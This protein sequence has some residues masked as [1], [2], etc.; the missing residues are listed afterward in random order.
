[1]Q[2]MISIIINFPTNLGDTIIS[3][4]IL[5]RLK[6]NF[7]ESKIT[8]IVSPQT[9]EFLLRNTFID[10]VVVFDKAWKLRQKMRFSFSLRGKYDLIVDLK[11]SLLPVI[12]GVKKRTP[13][14]RNYPKDIH[15]KD[16]YLKLVQK[17]A[18]IFQNTKSTFLLEKK[19]KEKWSNLNLT[20]AIFVACSARSSIK[21]YSY[22]HL[23]E[24][25]N[26]LLKKGYSIVVLGTK[27]EVHFYK[28]ILSLKGV[29]D[30][31]G[32]TKMSDCFYL[33]EKYASLVLCVDS[34]LMHLASYLNLPIVAL[35]GPTNIKR[36]SPW[37]ANYVVLYRKDL[38]CVFCEKS[39]CENPRCMEILPQKVIEA[40]EEMIARYVL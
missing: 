9:K 2:R 32:E 28:D 17:I 16:M 12:L 20:K 35:F 7:P 10:E 13:F 14:C 40:I 29:I 26:Q 37:S 3:L 8:A 24:V 1:M 38:N 19:E 25:I 11:N 34:A 22:S 27:E 4:P 39:F 6:T 21:C 31:V 15:A 36:Y 23:K 33:L 18:P 5:D 30:L